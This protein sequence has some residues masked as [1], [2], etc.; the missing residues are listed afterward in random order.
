M[1]QAAYIHVP[2][3]AHRCGYCNFA[4]VAG[5]GELVPAYLD[6]IDRELASLVD[7]PQPV[8]T[9]YFGGGTPTQLGCEG[10]ERLG[11]IVLAHHPLLQSD[12]RGYEWTIEANPADMSTDMARTIANSGAN[13]L[14][15]GGQSFR[16]EKLKLLERDHTAS[17]IIRSMQLAHEHKLAVS[18][19][20]IFATPDET[21]DQWHRDLQQAI[22]LQPEH[23]SVYGLTFE[24]GTTYWGRLLRGEL[25]ESEDELQ[26]DMYLSTIER[27]N[28]AG[29]EH[30]EVSN[31]ARPGHRSRHNETY[32]RGDEYFAAGPGAARY[33]AGVRETNHRSTTTYL[34]RVQAGESPVAEREQLDHEARARERL[35]F[36]LRRLEGVDRQEFQAATGY[37]V[38]QLAAEAIDKFVDIGLLQV[39][40]HRVKLTREG[41]LV[42][43]AMWPE[44]L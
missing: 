43:D 24:K 37:A 39:D 20:L 38:E 31:F 34:R 42:S 12:T 4:V 22:D 41:L 7:E 16:P 13:R 40:D 6:A 15:L 25:V 23:I 35:V 17:D 3:C 29:Y 2:F 36:G 27:L 1:P 9:L 11:E 21:L 44:M 32:W 26:R 5:R 8:I 18:L 19:D 14:S 30:Y 10:L 28:Q 33:V